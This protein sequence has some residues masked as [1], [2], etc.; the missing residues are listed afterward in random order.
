M[1]SRMD[2]EIET[3]EDIKSDFS[4]QIIPCGNAPVEQMPIVLFILI[5]I[6]YFATTRVL[7]SGTNLIFTILNL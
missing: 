7:D 4:D 5:K 2:S 3:L 6:L 1:E